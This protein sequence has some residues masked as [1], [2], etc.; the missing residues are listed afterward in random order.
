[1][2]FPF[3]QPGRRIDRSDFVPSPAMNSQQVHRQLPAKNYRGFNYRFTGGRFIERSHPF[4]GDD[5]SNAGGRFIVDNLLTSRTYPQARTFEASQSSRWS[6]RSAAG[7][8]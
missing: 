6:W 4:R 3:F 5:S 7:T 2:P 8:V 1:M